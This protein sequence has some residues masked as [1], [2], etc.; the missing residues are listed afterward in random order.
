MATSQNGWPVVTKSQ[1]DQGPFAGVT[2][3]NGILRGDVAVVARWQMARYEA[4]VEQLKAGTCWGWYDRAIR[5]STTISNHA[6]ATAWD[7]N[8]DKHPLGSDP[9]DNFSAAQ[10]AACRAIVKAAGGVLRWGGDYSGR[11]D[12][13]HW[14]INAS[15]AAV[16]AFANKIRAGQV[17]G[18]ED[19]VTN[20]DID[21]IVNAVTDRLFGDRDKG[22]LVDVYAGNRI[23]SHEVPDGTVAG[24]PQTAFYTVIK[25][26]GI[27]LRDLSAKVDALEKAAGQ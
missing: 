20:D 13:M 22:P 27:M 9:R 11:K 15:A 5:G 4:T 2:F 24:T 10:I 19:D 1:C 3:P 16:H 21:K 7:C 25:N 17:S 26:M 23:L 14:E 8:A 6:S 12:P 18:E